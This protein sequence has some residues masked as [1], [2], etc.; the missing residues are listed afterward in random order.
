M[1]LPHEV[2]L[3]Q[4][5]TVIGAVYLEGG[6]PVDW[7]QQTDEMLQEVGCTIQERSLVVT[8]VDLT[9]VLMD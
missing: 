8:L 4:A 5:V 9:L 3:G 1:D 2:P 6:G 7:G